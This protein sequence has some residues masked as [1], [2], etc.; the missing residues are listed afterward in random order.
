MDP[1]EVR[2]IVIEAVEAIVGDSVMS[3]QP[4]ME[5][6]IDS[7][8]ATELQQKLAESLSIE[9]PSTLVFDY[10]TI[11]AMSEF[12]SEQMAGAGANG[13]NDMVLDMVPRSHGEWTGGVS[14]VASAGQEHVL[15]NW[16]YG[17]ASTRVPIDRWDVTSSLLVD[18]EGSMP[19]Q[20][21]VFMTDVELF[22]PEVFGLLRSEAI[23]MDPQQRILLGQTLSGLST[24]GGIGL[25][26]GKQAGVFVGIAATDY[27]S[28]SHRN[29]MPINAFS[30]TSASPSVASG[31]LAYVFSAKGPAVSVDTACS[32]SLV[33]A[34][35]A[36]SAFKESSLQSAV[37][38]GVL[39]CLVP[40]ST[41]MLTRAQMISP[42]GRSKTLDA[43]AD[44]Y[45]RGEAARTLI[46]C[47]D[48]H[49]DEN[50]V[51][52]ANI[53]GS[54]VNTNGRASSLTAPNGP[55]QQQLL[56]EAW[57]SASVRPDDV[58]GLQL[59]SNGTSLGDPIEI[60][61][62]S[63]VA[64]A[65]RRPQP[66]LL[67]TVKGYTGHQ[68]S[69]AGTVGITEAVQVASRK[70]M[71]PALHLRHLNP[72]VYGALRDRQV[73]IARSGPV[74]TSSSS[75]I[76]GV[77][78]G[79]SSFGAQGTNAHA[80]I[81]AAGGIKSVEVGGDD[82]V[83][84][85]HR[86]W[87][88]PRVA[89]LLDVAWVRR[90]T[91]NN[92]GSVTFE[93]QIS[94]AKNVDFMSTQIYGR[95]H[96]L[97]SALLSAALSGVEMMLTDAF[98]GLEAGLEKVTFP[99]PVPLPRPSKKVNAEDVTVTLLLKPVTGHAE[100]SYS[101]RK[102]MSARAAMVY[103]N[104][105][106]NGDVVLGAAICARVLI[107]SGG[108]SRMDSG[109]TA[110]RGMGDGAGAVGFLHVDSQVME[111]SVDAAR[112]EAAVSMAGHHTTPGQSPLTWV[113]S[114]DHA[115]IRL[116]FRGKL[117]VISTEVVEE[118]GWTVVNSGAGDALRINSLV[119]GE[120]DLPPT[121]PAPLSAQTPRAAGDEVGADEEEGTLA[122]DHPLLLM[123]EDERLMHIQSQVMNE[124]K[125]VVGHAIHPDEPLMTAGL[126]SRGGMEL[127]RMLA[128]SLGLELPVTLLYDY[129]SIDEIVGYINSVVLEASADAQVGAIDDAE[130]SDEE[131]YSRRRGIAME[132]KSQVSKLMKTLRPPAQAKPLFLA[133]PGVANAQSAY[134]AF[135]MFLQWS[136]QPIYVLDKDNDLDLKALALQNAE[137]I[138]LIQPEGPYLVG[139]HSYG[140]AVAV[141]IAMVLES[142]GKEVGLVLIM[143]TPLKEQIRQRQPNAEKADDSDCLEL[144][145]MILGALGRDALG[146]GASMAH[147]KDS[148]EWKGMTM[149][150][151]YEFF[152][153]I[154]RVMRDNNMTVEEVKEQ[155]EY[156]ALV[157]KQGSQV[158]D[159]RVHDF[160]SPHL[161]APVVYFRGLIPGM[162][163]YFDDRKGPAAPY[164]H[165]A[166]WYERC[167]DLRVIDVP[168]DHFSLLRQDLEDMNVLVT[169]LKAILGPFGWS[170]TVSHEDKPEFSVSADQIQD[171]DSY[172]K[173]MGVDNPDLRRRLEVSMPYATEEGVGN[174][175]TGARKES[176]SALNP[177]GKAWQ[178]QGAA[179]S[180]VTGARDVEAILLVCC[181]AN[182]SLGGMD[183]VFAQM[184]LPVFAIYVPQDN[185][186]W[187]APD[188]QELATVAV[189]ALQRTIPLGKPM[190]ISGVGF[191]GLLAHEL[192][193]HLDSLSNN[194]GALALFE[195]FNVI[196]NMEPILAMLTGET[197]Y[198]TC[199]AAMAMYPM[200]ADS[201]GAKAPSLDEF[202]TKL[203]SISGFD[204]QLD[205]VS[206]FRPVG[207]SD[208]E[209]DIQVDTALSRLGFYKTV[210]DA[211]VPSDIFPGQTL[212]VSSSEDGKAIL[213]PANVWEP[214]RFLVQPV[215]LHVLR[216][217]EKTAV[218]SSSLTRFVLDAV[219]R[220]RDAE[221]RATGVSALPLMSPRVA[222]VSPASPSMGGMEMSPAAL[223][224]LCVVSPLNRLC[225]E[226]RYILRSLGKR[227]T[228]SG[229][230][231]APLSR[232]PV[233]MIHTERGDVS[234]AQKELAA[235]IRAPCYG[236]ALGPDAEECTSVEELASAYAS[237]IT[238]MQPTAPYLICGTSVVG[239]VIAHAIANH[240]M[241]SGAPCGLILIDGCVSPPSVPLH[242]TTWYG[243]FYLL[244]EIGTLSS[245]I[246]EFVDFIQGAGSPA[247]Q[248]KFLTSFKPTDPQVSLTSWETAVYATLDRAASLK[249]I[250][251]EPSSTSQTFSGPTALIVPRD[252]LGKA[253]ATA[254][255][256]HCD[257]DV[258]NLLLDSRHSEALLSRESRRQVAQRISKALEFLLSRAG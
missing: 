62:I 212:V 227:G 200:I 125:Q 20:F 239:C 145:E 153:P 197:A 46:L 85:A 222:D 41:L 174:A 21:G 30:F 29:G 106:G 230:T 107:P 237:A 201:I 47:A 28:L 24:A 78:M 23:G 206:S 249:R 209:W 150:Q 181:D 115:C 49:L 217:T 215:S 163:S 193:L 186:L 234:G 5:A 103:D 40:E 165:G 6:G 108:K 45:A 202:A 240:F 229:L 184:E 220:R 176:V 89:R 64:L 17:D 155:I 164:P 54:A 185:L 167:M 191:G 84:K 132:A 118:D 137:D 143:D 124:V 117:E 37:V 147:P 44:G 216:E 66:F 90:R 70:A 192:A 175:F 98:G 135:S 228:P 69:A 50:T 116:G 68:E 36:C 25:V 198:D 236:L 93:S 127:R 110:R 203:A 105:D 149:D 232:V 77:I 71:A 4:L 52:I 245:S 74:A 241:E 87:V 123:T 10:P 113:R 194:V 55:A 11:D 235:Q 179:R 219:W 114:I 142:W 7:L 208:A 35:M 223:S 180:S 14:L 31:R 133:A 102:V 146:M 231:T 254:S 173:K 18:R 96:L 140:G 58:N 104:V 99:A 258:L 79:V 33:A 111:G 26:F 224:T 244:K 170:E 160:S 190:V 214:I 168:G 3:D 141:E 253:L 204:G 213:G 72:H 39:L 73:L 2:E 151:K 233:W 196:R 221:Q 92:T 242:D 88:A 86:M 134:F 199:Q 9:L 65:R 183:A 100:V 32:A 1:D 178:A 162:C 129:Q 250:G 27:E 248:L 161:V 63:A 158:S 126:D 59:H 76:A 255:V 48:A 95:P 122:A 51:A 22:D 101:L 152:A 131:G 177:A 243:M 188:L 207:L 38:A 16:K 251:V 225:P 156:V 80:V 205:Y 148:D 121:S 82:Y 211:Y 128:E 157:T 130:F 252:R 218:K 19:S 138:V 238:E 154:W 112:I 43:S 56:R 109:R 210:S 13:A 257:G 247:N 15:Q 67:A 187:E 81:S 226:R 97:A 171:I 91:R 195:G 12:I 159:L 182:G 8:G 120:H 139:G 42:E 75:A 53:L 57:Y 136:T 166:C 61:A 169:G 256:S 34:N 189:K 144:M 94:S 119:V 83:W 172:L 246:G 60:G